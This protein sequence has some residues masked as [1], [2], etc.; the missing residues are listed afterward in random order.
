MQVCANFARISEMF[1]LNP[2]GKGWQSGVFVK[3]DNNSYY[4]AIADGFEY[5]YFDLYQKC[6]RQDDV[7][8]Y[9]PSYLTKILKGVKMPGACRSVL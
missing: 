3:G 8:L 7:M 4:I 2:G 6:W 9:T 5:S 1:F